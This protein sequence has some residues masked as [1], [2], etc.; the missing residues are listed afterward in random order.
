MAPVPG[1]F[2]STRV[3]LSEVDLVRYADTW[4]ARKPR[5]LIAQLN[6][7]RNTHLNEITTSQT[8]TVRPTLRLAD[9]HSVDIPTGRVQV[10]NSLR[11]V[12]SWCVTVLAALDL[13]AAFD[14]I[15]YSD[16]AK[17]LERTFG[18]NDATLNWL[19]SYLN[20]RSRFVKI[21]DG[22]STTTTSD[23]GVPQGS[24]LGPLLF[25]L[26]TIPLDDVISHY[27]VKFHQYADDTQ[28]YLTVNRENSSSAVLDLVGCTTAV[29]DWLLA[30]LS[31]SQ[32]EQVGGSLVR[33]NG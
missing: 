17:R 9:T 19:K 32:P 30:Q 23:T 31:R 3:A 33:Y 7:K 1:R 5:E 18:H 27:G 10:R 29:C 2:A 22:S 8:D 12:E 24:C 6:E 16:L 21:W 26:S 25:S 13:S 11:A 28:I 4:F 15:D 20:G 14:K